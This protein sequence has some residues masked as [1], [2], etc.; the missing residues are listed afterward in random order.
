MYPFISLL[1]ISPL[2]IL[3][4]NPQYFPLYSSINVL[5]KCFFQR[6]YSLTSI[7]ILEFSYVIHPP[8][9]SSPTYTSPFTEGSPG[10]P[11]WRWTVWSLHVG[12]SEGRVHLQHGQLPGHGNRGS[13]K[14]ETPHCS[15]GHETPCVRHWGTDHQVLHFLAKL[16]VAH[17]RTTLFC[18]SCKDF[19]IFYSMNCPKTYRSYWISISRLPFVRQR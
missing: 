10:F 12:M 2:S 14:E 6:T 16:L 8:I 17:T 15:G 18:L 1:L 9:V 19:I 3:I 11:C 5:F 7:D 4:Q 13:G